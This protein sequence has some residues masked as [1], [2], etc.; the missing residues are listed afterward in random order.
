MT[1]PTT[2][3][4][5]KEYNTLIEEIEILQDTIDALN[6]KAEIAAEGTKPKAWSVFMEEL[7]NDGLFKED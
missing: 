6:A 5:V 3:I 1:K 2:N 7:Y 4:P